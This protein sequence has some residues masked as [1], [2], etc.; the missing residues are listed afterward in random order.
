[1]S[2]ETSNAPAP[3]KKEIE[4]PADAWVKGGTTSL[5]HDTQEQKEHAEAETRRQAEIERRK[6][7]AANPQEAKS[8]SM[9]L[10]SHQN[11]AVVVL[12]LKHPKDNRVLDWIICELTQVAT[13]SGDSELALNMC[14][15]RCIFTL[16]RHPEKSQFMIR[17]SNRMFWLD[18][19]TRMQR[20]D[21]PTSGWSGAAGELFVNPQAPEDGPVTIAGTITTQD[22]ITCPHL[23]CG[24][25]CKI[26]DSIVYTG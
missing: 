14:C 10:G 9:D 11:H 17:Q 3:E 26:D 12:C 19:R 21:N 18:S 2:D 20:R 15:P 25:R 4:A 8:Y 23:G 6:I 16:N 1:M 7:V 5:R 13:V 22:W 24:W